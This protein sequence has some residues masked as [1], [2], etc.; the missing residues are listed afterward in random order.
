M[1]KVLKAFGLLLLVFVLISALVALIW[2]DDGFMSGD[3]VGVVYIEGPIIDPEDIVNELKE[4]EKDDSI[5]AVVLR[6]NSPGGAVAPSQEIFAAVQ[7]VAEAKPI[8]ASMGTLGASGGY[9]VAAPCTRIVA[10]P[11]TLTGSIG[12]IIEIPNIEGLLDKVGLRTEV[13]KSGEFKDMGSGTRG[14]SARDREIF[15][16]VI[17]DVYE[18]F[19]QDVAESR[20]MPVEEVMELADGRIYTGRQAFEL[21]LVDELGGMERAVEVVAELAEIEGEP[22]LVTWKEDKG[23]LGLLE[24][25]ISGNISDIF[26][27]LRLKYLM[28]T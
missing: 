27:H 22:K 28:I 4:Y 10:N 13:V 7:R 21:G 15:Q 25:R 8:V 12:V 1:K 14:M 24:N 11:G 9:Y 6:I 23:I 26:P 20:A 2:G 18:Q 16:A 17:D 5:R 19:V 3:M